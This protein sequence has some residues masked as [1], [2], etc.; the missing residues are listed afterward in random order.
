MKVRFIDTSQSRNA[1]KDVLEN[2]I[3]GNYEKAFESVYYYDVASD[4]EP[5]ISYE[6]AKST[7]VNR[8]KGL[9]EEGTYLIDYSSLS[10]ELDDAYP[11][12][13]VTLIVMENGEKTVKKNVRLWFAKD[14]N[15]WKLGNLY[16]SD[17]N[18]EILKALSGNM[19]KSE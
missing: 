2:V 9:K 8:V 18:V 19:M 7:W 3:E 17:D 11:V 1:A 12:G 15:S 16:N 14:Q 6:D 5:I 10:V 4:L 13:T